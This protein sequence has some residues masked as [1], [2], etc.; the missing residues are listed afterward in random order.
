MKS[1]QA[2]AKIKVYEHGSLKYLG[3][4]ELVRA[5]DATAAVKTP[6]EIKMR[7]GKVLVGGK[8]CAWRP[9]D[10]KEEPTVADAREA[11]AE[12]KPDVAVRSETEGVTHGKPDGP[13][14]ATR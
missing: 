8:D 7:D 10:G 9:D 5:F 2:G 14:S 3:V 4:G 1:L 11:V 13:S 12:A 6:P